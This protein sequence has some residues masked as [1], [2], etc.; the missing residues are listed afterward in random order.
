MFNYLMF[1]VSPWSL[2]PYSLKIAPYLSR[3]LY[4]IINSMKFKNLL[5][6]FILYIVFAT[7][8]NAQTDNPSSALGVSPAIIEEVLSPGQS[9]TVPVTVF[10]LTNIPLPIRGAVR[11]FIDTPDN[12]SLEKLEVFDSS[13]W[14]SLSQSDFILQPNQERTL[15]VTITPPENAEPGGHYATIYFQPLIPQSALSTR[16]LY[17]SNR[18]GVLAFLILPG[19]ISEKLTVST[20]KTPEFTQYGPI[21][22]TVTLTNSGNIHAFPSGI[23]TITNMFGKE[24]AQI[25]ITPGFVLPDSSRDFITW[26]EKGLLFGKYSIR[27][28]GT[29]GNDQQT[30]ES[31]PYSLWV[32]PIIPTTFLSLFVIMILLSLTFA[33]QRVFRA[34]K[35]LLG[36]DNYPQ[37]PRRIHNLHKGPQSHRRRHHS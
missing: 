18:V 17:V 5:G 19:D 11:S 8:I 10:N 26:W 13:N 12:L 29:Y 15:T 3:Y 7:P 31:Q 6:V 24:S 27:F 33:R 22:I 35:I 36:K 1:D 21:E 30:L 14:F 16:S 20:I 34:A 2:P 25:P 28:S 37:T 4:I 32:I 23:I 9:T